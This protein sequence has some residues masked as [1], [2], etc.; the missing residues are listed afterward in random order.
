M[1]EVLVEKS[2]LKVFGSQCFLASRAPNPCL[3]TIFLG[4]G[5]ASMTSTFVMKS[6]PPKKVGLFGKKDR[7]I[8]YREK[9]EKKLV[10]WEVRG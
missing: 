4:G 2:L 6:T 5:L 8:H 10:Y 9:N 7:K 3:T 1:I